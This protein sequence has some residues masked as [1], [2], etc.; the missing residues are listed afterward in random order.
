MHSAMTLSL[1][2]LYYFAIFVRVLGTLGDYCRW[3]N[4]SYSSRL[5]VSGEVWRNVSFKTFELNHRTVVL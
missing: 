5:L 4:L 2:V 3:Q 1:R